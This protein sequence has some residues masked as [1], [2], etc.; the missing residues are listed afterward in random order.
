MIPVVHRFI[1]SSNAPYET[2]LLDDAD[3]PWPLTGCANFSATAKNT[4]TGAVFALESVVVTDAASAKIRLEWLPATFSMPGL[5]A[6]QINCTDATGHAVTLPS[7]E[8]QLLFRVGEK[9]VL[10]P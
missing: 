4:Q 2:Q 8:G 7:E 6:V 9:I 1:A 5:Y 3:V 10:T